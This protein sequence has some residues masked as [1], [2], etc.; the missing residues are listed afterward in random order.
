MNKFL[1]GANVGILP[2]GKNDS[3]V[4]Y[5]D[6]SCNIWILFKKTNKETLMALLFWYIFEKLT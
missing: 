2:S 3:A 4:I 5:F 1:V 6:M